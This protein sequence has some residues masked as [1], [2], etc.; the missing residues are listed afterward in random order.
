MEVDNLNLLDKEEGEEN[1]EVDVEDAENLLGSP[2][3]PPITCPDFYQPSKVGDWAKEAVVDE[4][5]AAGRLPDRQPHF[6]QRHGEE[7]VTDELNLERQ[8]QHRHQA[9]Q[10]Q[11]RAALAPP[12][13]MTRGEQELQRSIEK[14]MESACGTDG[15]DGQE[16]NLQALYADGIR[17]PR[18]LGPGW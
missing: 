18:L 5:K 16:A 12:T 15:G 8:H 10:A 4:D 6:R 13:P 7:A 17:H 2:P 14:W 3:P 11:R 9:Q 1:V